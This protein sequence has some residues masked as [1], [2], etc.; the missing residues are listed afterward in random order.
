M[1]PRHEAFIYANEDVVNSIVDH[2]EGEENSQT[3]GYFVYLVNYKGIQQREEDNQEIID[4]LASRDA[5]E[6]LPNDNKIAHSME[7]VVDLEKEDTNLG[8]Y[9]QEWSEIRV[10][11]RAC[12]LVPGYAVVEDERGWEIGF[13]W[14]REGVC[15]PAIY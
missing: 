13:D 3:K 15:E 7:D 9:S 8:L 4:M 5:G 1:D 10:K 2:P 12:Y 11:F 6:A 14:P